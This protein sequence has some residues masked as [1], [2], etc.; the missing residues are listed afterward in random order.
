MLLVVLTFLFLRGPAFFQ[1]IY[2]PLPD[3]YRSYIEAAALRHDINPYLL[4]AVIDAE[5]DWQSDIV[6]EAGAVG[7]M[8]LLPE[9]AE[10]LGAGGSVDESLAGGVL[11]DPA[12]NIEHGAAYL[13]FLIGRYHEVEPALAA[14]N[15]GIGNVDEWVAAGDDIRETIEFPETRHYVLRV[16]RAK[17][18][19]EEL[20][21]DAF[22]DWSEQQR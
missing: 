20:Y 7:L 9:T 10:E 16:V 4:A 3:E 5:S 12:V 1:R 13:R 2:Y 6:S 17:D 19:Y 21:P 15:A 14:Y 8:Q 22:P 11:S 18:R